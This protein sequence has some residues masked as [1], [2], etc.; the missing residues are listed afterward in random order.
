MQDT[1][2]SFIASG[3]DGEVPIRT[4][5]KPEPD[6]HLHLQSRERFIAQGATRG[7]PRS[8]PGTGVNYFW[9]LSAWMP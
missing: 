8:P 9:F 3:E 2:Y 5:R 1:G 7:F 6:A 4:G